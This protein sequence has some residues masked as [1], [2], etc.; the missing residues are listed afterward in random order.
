MNIKEI[1]EKNKN[2]PVIYIALVLAGILIKA[3]LYSFLFSPLVFIYLIN[4]NL[5]FVMLSLH[6]S[7]LG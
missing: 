3:I 2:T 4:E 5:R 6:N 1:Y 7:Y